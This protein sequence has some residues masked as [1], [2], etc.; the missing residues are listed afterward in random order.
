MFPP[1]GDP[2]TGGAFRLD[3]AER[4]IAASFTF[5]LR[6]H[7]GIVSLKHNKPSFGGKPD[8]SF[9]PAFAT[10]AV[11]ARDEVAKPQHLLFLIAFHVLRIRPMNGPP[12]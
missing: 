6:N 9:R 12:L 7:K 4:G 3:E 10:G 5:P 8:N 11:T 1:I 2:Y